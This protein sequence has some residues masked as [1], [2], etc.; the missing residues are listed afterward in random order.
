MINL[1]I[2][3]INSIKKSL[4]FWWLIVTLCFALWVFLSLAILSLTNTLGVQN[5]MIMNIFTSIIFMILIYLLLYNPILRL[6]RTVKF[7]HRN[8]NQTI[9]NLT[10]IHIS[11]DIT[12]LEK[13]TFYEL[14]VMMNDVIKKVY[15]LS[16][17]G[18]QHIQMGE[19]LMTKLSGK[20]WMGVSHE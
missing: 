16:S 13:L 5:S 17:V 20:Y 6:H 2:S 18:T 11:D 8:L 4:L 12:T 10:I 14:E 19:V 7:I 15:L 3:Y 1:D 9:Q